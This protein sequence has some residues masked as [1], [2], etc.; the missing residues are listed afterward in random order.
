MQ[1]HKRAGLASPEPEHKRGGALHLHWYGHPGRWT[2][3]RFLE[4]FYAELPIALTDSSKRGMTR[5]MISD[6][7]MPS[8]CG[9]TTTGLHDQDWA[10]TGDQAAPFASRILR[11]DD[12]HG[13]AASTALT[14]LKTAAAHAGPAL[15]LD[16]PRPGMAC[17]HRR[18]PLIPPQRRAAAA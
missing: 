3:G 10:N 12:L 4:R 7:S 6:I 5:W 1:L 18:F 16:K 13:N 9:Q 11:R 8:Q 17:R 2:L 14:D 15:Q